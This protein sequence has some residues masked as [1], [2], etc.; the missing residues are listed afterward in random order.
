LKNTRISPAVQEKI[1]ALFEVET[2]DAVKIQ[3]A[4]DANV[5]PPVVMPPVVAP[6][7][8]V[9][10]A[11][12][13]RTDEELAADKVLTDAGKPP[14][15]D[16]E[17]LAQRAAAAV[18]KL[19]APTNLLA[20][21]NL[22]D[23]VTLTWESSNSTATGYKIERGEAGADFKEIGSVDDAKVMSYAERGVVACFDCLYRVRA[24]NAAGVSGYSNV[25]S[26]AGDMRK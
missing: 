16:T 6:P 13:V 21:A 14:Y 15:T 17:I 4:L 26:A 25:T 23:T 18:M 22:P 9:P 2:A 11:P 7:V 19:E 24:F 5:V 20:V 1:D 12:V 8:V 3:A 10:P